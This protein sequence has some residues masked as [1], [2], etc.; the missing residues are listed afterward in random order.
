MHRL[1]VALSLPELAA[2]SLSQLQYGIDGARWR[3]VETLHL[4]LQF[5]GQ[6]DRHGLEATAD[7]L[8]G[9]FAPGFSMTIAGCDFFGGS[10]PRAVWAGVKASAELKHLQNKIETALR[11]A[12]LSVENRKFVPHITLAYLSHVSQAIVA[13]YC[14]GH[15]M[16]SFGPFSVR[17]FHLYASYLG[18]EAAH[19]EIVETYTLSSSR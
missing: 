16:Y 1:F 4:T 8:A 3:P 10:K 18:G 17:D 5:I 19:Y 12:D 13:S 14:A 11:R 15:A 2:D 6:V 9:V 7:A